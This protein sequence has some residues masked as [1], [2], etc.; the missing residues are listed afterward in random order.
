MTR[1]HDAKLP[2]LFA[3]PVAVKIAISPSYVK[4]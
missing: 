3:T 2:I 4:D 1:L